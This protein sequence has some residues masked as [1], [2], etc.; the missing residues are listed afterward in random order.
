MLLKVFNKSLIQDKEKTYLSVAVSATGTSLTVVSTD[1][2]AAG[3]ASNTWADNDYMIVGEIGSENAEIMQVA[4]A[5]T[6]SNTI[7]ID[8]EGSAG[9]LRYNHSVGEPVYRVDFNQACFYNNT[10]DTVVGATLMTTISVQVDDEFTRYEDSTNTTGYGFVRFK[11]ATTSA[12]SSY[13]DGVNYESGGEK[14]SKDPR[15]LW[16][17]RKKVR[18]LIDEPDDEKVSDAQIV[19]ALNDKQRDI[20]HQRLWS[21]YE[22]EKSLS[23]VED[24]FA[25]D[26]PDKVHKVHSVRIDTQPLIYWNKRKW[27]ERHWNFN[28]TASI[29]SHFTVWNDQLLFA[30][31]PASS[32][33]ST[34]LNANITAA[35]TSI[36][37][38]D[39]GGFNR[40]DYY[41]FLIDSEVIYATDLDHA[42]TTTTAAVALVDVTI[43]ATDTTD[44]P[45]SGTIV[46]DDDVITYTGKT[47][48]SFTGVTGITAVH[49]SGDAIELY[50]FTGCLRGQ[51]GTTA[52]THTATTTVTERDIVLNVHVE[53]DMLQDTQ[54]RTAIPEPEVLAYGTAMDLALLIGK[55]TLHDRLKI[56]YDMAMKQLEGKFSTKQSAQFGRIKDKDEFLTDSTTGFFNPNNYPSGLT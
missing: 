21:F 4:A 52:A 20:A 18:D 51:E 55:D 50:T 2:N 3:T 16:M 26:I 10:T 8:R 45:T 13:A 25:Y 15:T 38:V 49:S 33:E 31:R 23:L 44:F 40:G 19:D 14:S 12:Y 36:Y 42:S 22:Y 7:T 30:P 53:P 6:T 37:V 1:V 35:A 47:T 24:Q 56:K 43:S 9:G 48:T 29:S 34:T 39:G 46:I 17:L 11:N 41:R 5:I 28:S 54:D 27:D 32:A